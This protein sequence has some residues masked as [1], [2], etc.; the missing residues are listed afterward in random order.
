MLKN[1]A[2]EKEFYIQQLLT[3]EPFLEFTTE[4][5]V[6]F[7][8]RLYN[9]NSVYRHLNPQQGLEVCEKQPLV[10]HDELQKALTEEEQDGTIE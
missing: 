9:T 8:E 5:D 7:L 6:S 3:R 10:K 4:Q 2:Q 1:F